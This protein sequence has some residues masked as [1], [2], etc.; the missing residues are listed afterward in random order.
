MR[1]AALRRRIQEAA[2][3][4]VLHGVSPDCP[5]DV[6]EMFLEQVLAFEQIGATPLFEQLV[7]AGVAL[8]AP[9][10]IADKTLAAKLDQMFAALAGLGVYVQSTDHLSDRE[11]YELLWRET[12]RV[13]ETTVP[14]NPNITC[15]IDLV[16]TGSMEHNQIWLTYYASEEDREAWQADFPESPLPQKKKRPYYRDRGLPRWP[17][18]RSPAS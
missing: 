15:L 9:G 13:P 6:E 7:A 18:D 16:S 12:L 4:E 17:P 1:I 3:E 14:E 5:P 10:Q 11:L 8:P 2:G